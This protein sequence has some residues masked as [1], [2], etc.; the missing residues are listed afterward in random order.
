[1][2]SILFVCLGN[3]CRSP[4]AEGIAKKLAHEKGLSLEIDSAGTSSF[5]IGEP[6]C[7]NS[8]SVARENG[9]DISTQRSRQIRK[10]DYTYY[11]MVI[12]MDA[13]NMLDL[14][15]KGIINLIKLGDFG[16]KGEDVPDPYYFHAIEGFIQVYNMIDICISNLLDEIK[17]ENI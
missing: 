14:K 13:S 17:K 6:P 1:M 8:Q 7:E 3:I 4:L 2:K 16:Y 10:N 15:D 11:D 9:T 12:A 5:H